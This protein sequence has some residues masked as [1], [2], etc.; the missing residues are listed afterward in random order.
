[1]KVYGVADQ[2]RVVDEVE[3]GPVL[4]DFGLEE[5]LL[6]QLQVRSGIKGPGVPQAVDHEDDTVVEFYERLTADVKG[7][8][9][10]QN[11]GFLKEMSLSGF[12]QV[13][14]P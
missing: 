5:Q 8:V 13:S 12:M 7:L 1:M 10:G 2:G 11:V 4:R 3:A 14:V 6:S 9:E